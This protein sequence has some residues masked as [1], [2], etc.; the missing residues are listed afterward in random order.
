LDVPAGHRDEFVYHSPMPS[1]PSQ[2]LTLQQAMDLALRHL[3]GGFVDR[4][5]SIYQQIVAAE[6]EVGEAWNDL[7]SALL[8]VRRY[9]EA[10][11]ALRRAQALCP[12]L[13]QPISNLGN[14]LR[15]DHQLD[16]AIEVLGRAVQQHPLFPSAQTNLGAALFAAGRFDEAIEHSERAIQIQ[17]ELAQAH[18]NLALVLLLR[19]DWQRG[20]PE[21]EW[22]LKVDPQMVALRRGIAQPPWDGANPAGQRILVYAEQGL[23]DTVQFAR[24]LPLLAA[25]GAQPILRCQPELVDLMRTLGSAVTVIASHDPLPPFDLHAALLSLPLLFGG[26]PPWDVPL[27][28]PYLHA[29]APKTDRWK[30]RLAS[31]GPAK[32]V[33]LAWA[34]NP[35]H[36]NDRSRSLVPG[37]LAPLSGVSGVT[38]VSLQKESDGRLSL[39]PDRIELVDWTG[40]LRDFSDTAALIESLDL[41]ITADTAVA[42]LAGALG[43]P[44]WVLLP[45]VP[46]WRWMLDRQ[47]SPWYPTMRL[48]RQPVARDWKTPLDEVVRLLSTDC[49]CNQSGGNG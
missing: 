12:Q 15:L 29:Q 8:R 39:K 43:K 46:D 44:V 45:Y 19:G 9:R 47:D 18:H 1:E 25:R 32:K 11:D 23:G 31:L 24:Y 7:G 17:P 22:R 10:I 16:E 20:L 26:Q 5:V 38:F 14:A 28:V 36:E 49:P 3:Q 6:P 27:S 33:G 34:G 41:V 13:P 40:E 48:F 30:R 35:N 21:H 4:A 2:Q 42:H 37:D